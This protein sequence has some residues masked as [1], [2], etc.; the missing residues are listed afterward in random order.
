MRK[1]ARASLLNQTRPLSRSEVVGVVGEPLVARGGGAPAQAPWGGGA[2]CLRC[3][4]R[5]VVGFGFG[6]VWVRKK[7][8]RWTD[9]LAG[10]T[11]HG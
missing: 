5:V 8:D 6:L 3:F 4:W 9:G 2:I 7:K 1:G 11:R 10:R